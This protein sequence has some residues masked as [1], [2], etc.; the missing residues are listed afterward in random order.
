MVE[1]QILKKKEVL[2]LCPNLSMK[3]GVAYYYSLL[4]KY[5]Y[6]NFINLHFFFIGNEKTNISFY[7]RVLKSIFDLFKLF[8]HLSKFDLIILNPSLDPKALFRDGLIHL[9]A[10]L[11]YR[12]K[13][14]I[15]F[16]GWTPKYEQLINKVFSK[17]FKLIFKANRNIVLA[18]QFKNKFIDWGFDPK[19]I[20]VGNTLF[21]YPSNFELN[22][23]PN[24]IVF[25]SR[26]D[27]RKGCLTAIKTIEQLIHEFPK[28]KLY[29]VG[30][31]VLLPKLK[32]YVNQHNLIKFIKFTGWLNGRQK[33]EILAKSGIMLY[34]T[35]YGEGMPISIL[36]GMGF[37][38]AIIS[39]P[40]AGIPDIIIDGMNGFLIYSNNPSDFASK[41]KTIITNYNL[42]KTFSDTNIETANSKFNILKEI[43][44]IEKIYYDSAS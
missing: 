12:K 15:F 24:N 9:F 44:K 30:D 7:S 35:N 16:H 33:Y 21:E 19:L 5:F 42:W 20:I 2:I 27:K 8:K 39:R 6:S 22:N 36:E 32:E 34:P 4:K 23:S 31:G 11:I 43:K 37:G 25:L 13:S 26:F 17:S 10:K 3:G 38:L 29:M 41:I 14:I 1:S 28:I 40:V 18:K